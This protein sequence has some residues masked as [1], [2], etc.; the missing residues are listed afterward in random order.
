L[1]DQELDGFVQRDNKN[2]LLRYMAE[3]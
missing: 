3:Q 2:K 1:R